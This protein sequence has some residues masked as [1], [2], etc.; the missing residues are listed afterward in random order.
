V[1]KPVRW[2]VL[3]CAQIAI[4]RVIPGMQGADLTVLTA[5][6]SRSLAKAQETA[7]RFSVSKAY[8]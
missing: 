7:A 5:I 3:G 1:N 4:N 6:A 8:G 2:G